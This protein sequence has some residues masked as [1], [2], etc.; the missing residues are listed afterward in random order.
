M[1]DLTPVPRHRESFDALIQAP[2]DAET[3]VAGRR[4]SS[5]RLW[6]APVA[7]TV[8]TLLGAS[9][10]AAA[11]LTPLPNTTAEATLTEI[12]APTAS[13]SQTPTRVQPTPATTAPGAVTTADRPVSELA[14]PTWVAR[15]AKAGG[16][17][18]RALAAYT[19]A[20]LAAARTHPGCGIGW[21]TIAAIGFVESAHGNIN[22]ATL[23][24]DGTVTP[25]IIGIPLNGDGTNAVPDTD[26]GVV[27]GD[28]VWDRAVGPMQF[29]PSTWNA[30][31]QDGNRDGK[32]DI[33]QIDDAALT[34]A[35]HLC[36]VGGDL[37]Q[38]ANWIT[39]IN[40]Y[41]P[42]IDYNNRVADT[43]T[44]YATLG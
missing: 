34:T 14:D 35:L 44:Q 41:N 3:A 39:A 33:N 12:P 42:S 9:A 8:L 21:N 2:D 22:G 19:G 25:T 18:E 17:P 28:T 38:S 15:I 30:T 6:A 43:A 24:P 4:P 10:I 7:T 23:R 36:D 16:I 31:A 32:T 20:A 29:I 1:T 40:A 37:T 5:W 11:A 26:G 27:D 13:P